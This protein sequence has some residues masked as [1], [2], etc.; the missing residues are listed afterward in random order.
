[1]A[2]LSGLGNP[3]SRIERSTPLDAAEEDDLPEDS[4][5]DGQTSDY[6][7]NVSRDQSPDAHLIDTMNETAGKSGPADHGSS[8]QHDQPR[9]SPRKRQISNTSQVDTDGNKRLRVDAQQLT[10]GRLKRRSTVNQP[11]PSRNRDTY[12]FPDDLP[13]PAP[14]P[15]QLKR[16]ETVANPSPLK[17]KG[18]VSMPSSGAVESGRF[19]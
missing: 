14:A 19:A 15:R 7:N 16:K 5:A 12:E 4:V 10:G 8:F 6:P 3:L 17:G 1:M 18:I 13:A 9:R 11:R 2:R